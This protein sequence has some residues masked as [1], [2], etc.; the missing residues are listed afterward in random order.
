[1]LSG[2]IITVLALPA[3]PFFMAGALA[4]ELVGLVRTYIGQGIGWRVWVPSSYLVGLV[5]AAPG[6]RLKV[7]GCLMRPTGVENIYRTDRHGNVESI[8]NGRDLWVNTYR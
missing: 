8:T 1:M 4:A 7:E 6:W 5:E 3:L 2:I